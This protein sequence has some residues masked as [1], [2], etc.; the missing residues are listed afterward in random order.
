M[1]TSRHFLE[2]LTVFIDQHRG[3]EHPTEHQDYRAVLNEGLFTH[4][5]T[6]MSDF[7][8]HS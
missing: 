3:P 4:R 6:S 2:D 5:R 1:S 8:S 7:S